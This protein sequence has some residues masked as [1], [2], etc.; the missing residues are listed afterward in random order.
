MLTHRL[1]HQNSNCNLVK[2]HNCNLVK[3]YLIHSISWNSGITSDQ[4]EKLQWR[5]FLGTDLLDAQCPL[6]KLG[7]IIRPMSR[8]LSF[9]RV[10]SRAR[11]VLG[12]LFN[13]RAM[14]DF[15]DVL[16]ESVVHTT[17]TFLLRFYNLRFYLHLRDT[18]CQ[19]SSYCS[20]LVLI[21]YLTKSTKLGS[22]SPSLQ[23][24][25]AAIQMS[26]LYL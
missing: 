21:K 23:F 16:V 26:L 6:P 9:F 14:V 17:T 25:L 7:T 5:K 15:E 4:L 24:P 8:R 20:T 22:V 13:C 10:G 11:R 18:S 12:H 19:C 1:C 3:T 2:S